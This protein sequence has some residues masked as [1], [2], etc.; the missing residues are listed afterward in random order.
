MK[1]IIYPAFATALLALAS[2]SVDDNSYNEDKDKS[3]EVPAETLLAN[4]E[5]ELADQSATPDVNLNPFRFYTQYWASTQYPAESR[6]N[7]VT[8]NIANNL[9]NNL[10]RDVLGN[11]ESAKDVIEANPD[12]DDATKQNQNAIVEIIE[13]YTYQLLVDTYGDIPYSEALDPANVVPAYD[14]DAAIYPQLITRLDAALAQLDP[15]QGTFTS[16]D[17]LLNGDV[18]RWAQFGNTL[19]VKLG[20]A[21]G[22]VNSTLAQ[23]TIQ[24]AVT[25]GNLILT[26][27]DNV[28]FNYSGSA[29]FYNPIYAQLVASNRNDYVASATI[30]DALNG[31]DDPRRE[32]Y[33]K[34]GPDGTYVGGANGAGNNYFSFSAPGTVFENAALPAPLFEASEVNF[35]LAEAAARGYNVGGTAEEFYNAG[36]TT[37]FEAWGVSGADAYLADPAVAYSTAEGSWQ[38]KIGTQAWIALYN[39]TFEAWNTRRRLDYPV[40]TPAQNAVPI[41][42]GL[43]P[44]RFTYPINEQTVNNANWTAA[45]EAIGGDFL[46]TPVFWDVS[47]P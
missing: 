46:Y 1:K 45:S 37:S 17:I 35:Y 38:Q 42:N 39:R 28:T 5:R 36:I 8:R 13:V 19:K 43:I 41:S 16:G 6:Y 12:L 34:I 27:A 33:F 14:D 47:Q 31:L 7:I 24:S 10:F 23:S 32:A 30:V 4:A 40:L 3:Y 25:A 26:N 2:C 11:L 29:P 18:A 21:L 44:V 15:A 20:I 22:D 9:W